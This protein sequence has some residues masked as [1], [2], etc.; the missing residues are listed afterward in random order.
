MAQRYLPSPGDLLWFWLQHCLPGK[1][2]EAASAYNTGMEI[3]NGSDCPIPATHGCNAY[4]PGDPNEMHGYVSESGSKYVTS[5]VIDVSISR[6]ESNRWITAYSIV[7][8]WV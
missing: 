3:L 5:A 8:R 7:S 2:G 4:N 1:A 6:N